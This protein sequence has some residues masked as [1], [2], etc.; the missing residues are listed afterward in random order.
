MSDVWGSVE[1]VFGSQVHKQ[2]F[3]GR[4]TSAVVAGRS[5]STGDRR[6]GCVK[7]GEA[8]ICANFRGEALVIASSFFI[9]FFES[10][11][12]EGVLP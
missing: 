9:S 1:R 5:L 4:D 7:R 6:G 8:A 12:M 10:P 11:V 2:A 3:D